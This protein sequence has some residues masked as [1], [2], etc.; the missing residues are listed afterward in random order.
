MCVC[1]CHMMLSVA[2]QRSWEETSIVDCNCFKSI[3]AVFTTRRYN[4]IW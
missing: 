4:I 2:K 3:R 1:V